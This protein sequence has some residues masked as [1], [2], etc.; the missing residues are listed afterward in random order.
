[1]AE[2][3]I[4]AKQTLAGFVDT[5]AGFWG[6]QMEAPF[7][8]LTD[9]G[10]YRIVWDA[11]E[12]ACT[13]SMLDG[14]PFVGNAG[15]L[16]GLEGTGEP[17]G[18]GVVPA[19]L[20]EA[21]TDLLICVTTQEGSS[22]ELA[23]YQEVAEETK[24]SEDVILKNYSGVDVVHEDVPKVWLTAADGSG[25]IPFTYGEALDDV[26][27]ALDFSSGAQR[28]IL[29]P[30]YLA[31]SA[32]I[33]K[34]LT[35]I[36]ENIRKGA[37]VA[38][39]E[40]E[41][42]GDPE[43]VTVELNL[44]NG[45]QEVT[46]T[47]VGKLISKAI[48]EKPETL[49]P[50]NI[51]GGVKIA[52]VTGEFTGDTEE[53]TVELYMAGG[54][55]VIAPP[56]AGKSLS[57]VTIQKPATLAPE[58]IAKDI[59]IAGIKGTH[60]GGA[61]ANVP[62]LFSPFSISI[63]TV[64]GLKRIRIYQGNY[65]GSFTRKLQLVSEDGT[66]V[67][68][69]GSNTTSYDYVYYYAYNLIV[70]PTVMPFKICARFT[71]ENF[72]N[73]NLV[74]LSTSL[75]LVDILKNLVGCSLSNAYTWLFSGDQ[76][77]VTLKPSTGYYYPK[78]ILVEP[79]EGEIVYT[80]DPLTGEINIPSLP[81]AESVTIIAEAPTTPWLQTPRIGLN[82]KTLTVNF[83]DN[84]A[85]STPVMCNGET[86][87]ELADTRTGYLSS[88]VTLTAPSATYGFALQSD[89]Y[90]KENIGSSYGAALCKVT[91][92]M[93][94][95]GYVNFSIVNY[96]YSSYDYGIV[97]KVDCTLSTSYSTDI[98]TTSSNVYTT[99]KSSNSTTAKTL[100]I[101]VPAGEHF[102]YFKYRQYM[103]TS[104]SYYFK[105]K[106]T[107]TASAAPKYSVSD[108]ITS[109]G[110]FPLVIQSFA[111]GY[112][113][114]DTVELVYENK[115]QI[116]VSNVVLTV[117]NLTAEVTKLNVTV[118]GN[119]LT[120]LD[121]DGSNTATLDLAPYGLSIGNHTIYVDAILGDS[122]SYRSN[123][124][125]NAI[126]FPYST[127]AEADFSEIDAISKAGFANRVYAVGNTK[128]V[129]IGGV[130][131]TMRILDFNK[132]ILSDG[133]G[134]AGL[135]FCVYPVNYSCYF[136][137]AYYKGWSDSYPRTY[138]M[139]TFPTLVPAELQ[140]VLKP[141]NK[142][143]YYFPQSESIKTVQ[144]TWFIPS[145]AEAGYGSYCNEGT[146]IQ[147][148]G[149]DT[150]TERIFTNTSGTAVNCHT[151]S[152][153]NTYNYRITSTGG[154]SQTGTMQ[155][156]SAYVLPCACI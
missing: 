86:L 63:E 143:Y 142:S 45:N 83:I 92:N 44:A 55:Q 5:G 155:S 154:N 84:N 134:K 19:D 58:N 52:G 151:R 74:T 30:G 76:L 6:L 152:C 39:V 24:P 106:I 13:A 22:H 2:T 11:E 149:L 27:I 4:L 8:V 79:S 126:L 40:G 54:D 41:F 14:V 122:E 135:T 145:A 120:M 99:Y 50:E 146:G 104:T 95:A 18:F 127:F 68:A 64:G 110:V 60:E 100:S 71:G 96:G 73:S 61:S 20:D 125:D 31:R 102:I 98:D 87:L 85:E 121:H 153:H 111:E 15:I 108:Y 25:K 91:V 51:K 150:A 7:S 138:L 33:A 130:A 129:T 26:A 128:T 16:E 103:S 38:G 147:Y 66:L 53:L 35:L 112:T 72:L 93:K 131:R 144:D 3:I 36:P 109:Y 57:K 136:N 42:V 88:M 80:Y 37:T 67:Y 137:S 133:S 1:M 21:E 140:N 156:V 43:E 82:S 117:S 119:L 90:Y 113:P 48:I 32:L 65:N 78:T 77:S 9:G 81:Q 116:S 148:L 75:Y 34:P 28:V 107:S 46:P 114:S 139:N 105:F 70:K 12:Y 101:Y 115:P 94:T 69:E 29:P 123:T 56:T 97:S 89:G 59:V 141:V 124:L 23:V 49:I 47:G 118:D 17:F 62:Q 132:D 10:I